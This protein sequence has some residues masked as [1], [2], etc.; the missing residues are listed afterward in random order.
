M[1]ER[2]TSIQ[3]ELDM[4]I[5]L[6]LWRVVMRSALDDLHI[7]QRYAGRG[8]LWGYETTECNYSRDCEGDGSEEAKDI[9]ETHKGRVHPERKKERK[10]L[11]SDL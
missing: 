3:V 6:P 8:V 10:A 4:R 7:P 1:G 9:L 5:L 2:R 11:Y